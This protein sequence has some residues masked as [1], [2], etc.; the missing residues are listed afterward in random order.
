MD[1][2]EK[3]A[4][5]EGPDLRS[6]HEKEGFAAGYHAF[7]WGYPYV[8][9]MLLRHGAM[10]PGTANHAPLNALHYYKTLARSGF[11][12]FTPTVEALMNVGWV[13]LSQGAVL[14]DVPAIEDRYWSVVLVDAV[15]DAACYLGSR[16]SSAPGAY[17]LVPLGWEGLLPAGVTAIPVRSRF[18]LLLLRTLPARR[19]GL[20][21]GSTLDRGFRC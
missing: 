15:G 17:A 21:A 6:L 13:D 3:P 18:S 4:L 7:D 2:T 20:L 10:H 5:A 11:H 14:F 12:D 1:G 16:Q 9:G 8:K 19:V